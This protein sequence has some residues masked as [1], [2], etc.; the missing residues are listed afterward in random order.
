MHA[1]IN[2][3]QTSEAGESSSDRT[4]REVADRLREQPGFHAYTLV[5]TGDSE[6]VAITMFETAAQLHSAIESISDL[7]QSNI[8]NL[9][10]GKPVSRAGDVIYHEMVRG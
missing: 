3:W 2:I 10:A 8:H 9:S 6:V 1:H 7:T 5:R 4:S